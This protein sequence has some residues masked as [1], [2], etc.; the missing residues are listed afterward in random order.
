MRFFA[1]QM[2]GNGSVTSRI[3]VAGY[4]ALPRK[5]MLVLELLFRDGATSGHRRF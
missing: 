2:A 4:P 3:N 5:K 1:Y